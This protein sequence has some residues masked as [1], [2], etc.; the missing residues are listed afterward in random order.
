MCEPMKPV[1]PVTKTALREDDIMQDTFEGQKAWC[2]PGMKVGEELAVVGVSFD[3]WQLSF[4]EAL[5]YCPV[6]QQ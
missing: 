4:H 3:G 1:A 5:F 2:L 6:Q